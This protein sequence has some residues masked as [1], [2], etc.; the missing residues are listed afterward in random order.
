VDAETT[1]VA[2]AAAR[3]PMIPTR[4]TGFDAAARGS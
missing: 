2:S 4:F 1:G 3:T